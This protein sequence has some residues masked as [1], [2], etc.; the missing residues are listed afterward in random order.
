[1]TEHRPGKVSRAVFDRTIRTRLGAGDRRVLVGPAH[2]LDNGVLD[3]GGGQVLVVTTDPLFVVPAYGWRRAAWFALHIVASDVATSGFAPRFLAVN[4]SLPPS[5]SDADFE[6]FWS[7]F[8]DAADALGASIVT[9]HTGRYEGCAFPTIGAITAMATGSRDRFVTPAMARAGDTVLVTK[10][11]AIET[12][13][14]LAALFPERIRD[15]CGERVAREAN[16]MFEQMSVV[17]DAL[18]AAAAGVHDDGVTAMHDAT[19]FG[20]QGALV[21][22]AAASGVGL[23]LDR[24]ALRL[25]EAVAEVCRHFEMDP[26]AASSEGA[27]VLTVCPRRTA[28]V[29]S[30]LGDAG[31]PVFAIGDAVPVEQG[32]N[33]LVAGAMQPLHAPEADPFWPVLTRLLEEAG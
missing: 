15:A 13:G 22:L 20:V 28:D 33:W 31:I 30:R 19:E 10:G 4:C 8:H 25:P 27:L 14:Q 1:M 21:E 5:L 17:N 23:R 7:A 26:Y 18:V 24:D 6:A 9:G 2:G 29:C 32:T 3:V 11:A 16:A 12:V